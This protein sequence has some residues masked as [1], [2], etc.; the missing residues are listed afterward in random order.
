MKVEQFTDTVSNCSLKRR[1]CL[2]R[3]RGRLQITDRMASSNRRSVDEPSQRPAERE[4]VALAPI[5]ARAFGDLRPPGALSAAQHALVAV[6]LH[7]QPPLR[8]EL[9][10]GLPHA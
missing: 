8:S 3:G 10:G 9:V 7:S 2:V 6:G 4:G 1:I 5:V